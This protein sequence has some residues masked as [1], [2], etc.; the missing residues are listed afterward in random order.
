ML[1]ITRVYEKY[2][3][4]K[5]PDTVDYGRFIK[6]QLTLRQLSEALVWFKNGHV[7][8]GIRPQL[9]LGRPPVW[10]RLFV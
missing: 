6:G 1:Q 7:A 9:I 5:L 10:V 2:P 4:L 3:M 8:P